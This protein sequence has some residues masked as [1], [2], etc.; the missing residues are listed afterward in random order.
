MIAHGP[1]DGREASAMTARIV[2]VIVF[3]IYWTSSVHAVNVL[4]AR[5]MPIEAMTEEDVAILMQAVT[6]ALEAQPDHSTARWENPR[7]G[8]HGELTPVAS[9]EKAGRRCRDLEVA[10]SAQGRSNRLVVSLCRQDGGEWTV[11]HN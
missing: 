8:A 9:F 3:F 2:C 6:A 11:E 1:R 4:S 7:T 5:D 10:N